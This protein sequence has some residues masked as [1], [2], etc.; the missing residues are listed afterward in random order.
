[1]EQLSKFE[2]EARALVTD[3]AWKHAEHVKTI[4]DD[5]PIDQQMHLVM[6][7]DIDVYLTMFDMV[8][9]IN[10]AGIVTSRLGARTDIA[11][12][13]VEFYHEQFIPV[14]DGLAAVVQYPPC[15]D[16]GAMSM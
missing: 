3:V 10:T 8:D 1:M 11:T 2:S 12:A 13:L 5:A 16:S 14:R 7:D 9:K 15:I 4:P 6:K